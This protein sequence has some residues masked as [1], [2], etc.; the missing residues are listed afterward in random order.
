MLS[1]PGRLRNGWI[2]WIFPPCSG[3]FPVILTLYHKDKAYIN[4]EYIEKPTAFLGNT[5]VL[6]NGAHTAIWQLA[7]EEWDFDVL[8]SKLAHEMLY[9]HQNAVG[10]TRWADERAALVKYPHDAVNVSARLEEAA[11]MEICLSENDPAAF[12]RL[13]ALRKARM[14]RFPFAYDIRTLIR[15]PSPTR[16]LP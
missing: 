2:G 4:G 12:S 7:G 10:E 15:T 1:L 5:S 16:P 3:T 11:C 13:L 9:A 6:Y 14:E 8:A